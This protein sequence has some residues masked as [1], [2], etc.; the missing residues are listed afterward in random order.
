LRVLGRE[1][2]RRAGRRAD[3]ALLLRPRRNE[4]QIAAQALDLRGHA[5]LHALADGHQRDH[6]AHADDD[7]Q[8]RQ[9]GAQL[10]GAQGAQRHP[11]AFRQTHPLA[12]SS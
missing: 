8:H 3:A 1:R 2:W 7:P 10:V 12:A 11:D 5:R 9:R 6:G 4:Q